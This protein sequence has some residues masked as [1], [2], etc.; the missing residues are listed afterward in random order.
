MEVVKVMLKAVIFDLDGVITD[1]AKYHFLAWKSLADHLQIPFDEAYN[2]KLKGVS[3]LESLDLILENG[4]KKDDYTKEEKEEM[5][6]QKNEKY[7]KLISC[8]SAEDILPGILPFLEEL[9][10]K[11]I[12]TALASV[13]H[14][15]VFILERLGLKNSFDYIADPA[16]I[17]NAKPYP[18]IFLD[19]AYALGVEPSECI[20][21][22]DAKAG[23]QAI[24]AAG[25]KAVG[26][27]TVEQMRQADLILDSTKQLSLSI[28]L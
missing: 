5:A 1:S 11:Q 18:D 15:A 12:K 10:E 28:L 7:K 27:G 16:K 20:G 3:R 2:E 25:M 14:N 4:K 26:V 22:E 9:K 23:I 6:T 17:K 24:K 8:M 13:S 19:C 21:V